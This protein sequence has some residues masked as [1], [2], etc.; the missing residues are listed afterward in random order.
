MKSFIESIL[1]DKI[2]LPSIVQGRRRRTAT[3]IAYWTEASTRIDSTVMVLL[4]MPPTTTRRLTQFVRISSI[5][6]LLLQKNI[7]ECHTHSTDYKTDNLPSCSFQPY[8]ILENIQPASMHR[9]LF[10][11]FSFVVYTTLTTSIVPHIISI[12]VAFFYSNVDEDTV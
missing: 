1:A 9:Q 3:A 2:P 12:S 11:L 8:L 5:R 6:F 7:K 10:S 4:M